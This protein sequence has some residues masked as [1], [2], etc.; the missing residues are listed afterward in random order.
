MVMVG[1]ALCAYR[2]LGRTRK[3]V[4]AN[5]T[6]VLGDAATYDEIQRIV[7]RSFMSYG[8]YWSDLAHLPTLSPDALD[9]HFAEENVIAFA[10]VLAHRGAIIA[11][12]HLGS[13]EVAGYW[14]HLHGYTV[15]TV[16]EPASSGALT[17]WFERQR[18]AVGL[19][20]YLNGPETTAK[21][22]AALERDE[23]VALVAD[24]DVTGDGV[25]VSFFGHPVKVPGGPALLALRSGCP[26]VP[27]AVY[28]GEHDQHVPVVLPAI[29]VE[30]RGRLREDV[31]RITQDLVDAFEQLIRHAPEQWHVFQPIWS[32]RELGLG[33]NR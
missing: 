26:L 33:A 17:R 24:R 1:L 21:L 9:R 6:G 13:W 25:E 16:A 5:L 15:H 18:Q 10:N 12:P 8:R 30:R 29:A 32:E 22:L 19:N 2:L 7:R 11:L 14:A 23:L 27:V 28:Q 4:T 31:T 3:V 20:V